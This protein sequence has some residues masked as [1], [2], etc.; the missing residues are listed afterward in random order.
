M[1]ENNG[2][3]QT[4]PMRFSL[5]RREE[6]LILE[7]PGTGDP[8]H[9][10]LREMDGTQRDAYLNGMAG[11]IQQR[12]EVSSITN[13]TGLHAN[14]ISRCLHRAELELDE[15]GNVVR[16]IALKSTVEEKEVQRFP[17]SVQAE[18]FAI[19]QHMNGLNREAREEAK[20]S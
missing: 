6:P 12:G 1:S 18:L 13:Y 3:G 14:L 9:Y 11:R 10:V 5:K 7:D 19:C 15:E 20:N 16:V 4:K 2:A 8:Q 17:S